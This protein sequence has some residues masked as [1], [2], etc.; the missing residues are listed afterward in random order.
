MR[1]V[2]TILIYLLGVQAASSTSPLIMDPNICS[3]EENKDSS[4]GIHCILKGVESKFLSFENFINFHFLIN[5]YSLQ[6]KKFNLLFKI[7]PKSN[8]PPK[9]LI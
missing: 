5:D 9:N 2:F 4:C 3:S 7:E 1:I 6:I 8:S